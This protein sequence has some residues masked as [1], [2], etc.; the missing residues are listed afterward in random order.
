MKKRFALVLL[1]SLLFLPLV[2]GLA[3]GVSPSK[4]IIENALK[5]EQYQ[6]SMRFSTT[7]DEDVVVDLEAHGDYKDWVKF[8]DPEDSSNEITNLDIEKKGA[9]FAIAVFD[10][11]I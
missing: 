3:I 2:N 5:G 6:R 9:S 7:S 4:F 11:F 1:F 8:Y 10:T